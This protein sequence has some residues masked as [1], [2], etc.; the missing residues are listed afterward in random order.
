MLACL[1]SNVRPA[2]FEQLS[3]LPIHDAAIRSLA[4]NHHPQQRRQLLNIHK[5]KLEEFKKDSKE[6]WDTAYVNKRYSTSRF[7]ECIYA[8]PEILKNIE[9]TPSQFRENVPLV[10]DV[11]SNDKMSIN[12]LQFQLSNQ[13]AMLRRNMANE[14]EDLRMFQNREIEILI[15]AKDAR[16]LEFHKLVEETRKPGFRPPPDPHQVNKPIRKQSSLPTPA[17]V[18]SPA[19]RAPMAQRTASPVQI[20]S[21]AA[22]LPDLNTLQN[23][24]SLDTFLRILLQLTVVQR[25]WPAIAINWHQYYYM[26]KRTLLPAENFAKAVLEDAIRATNTTKFPVDQ[27]II[28]KTRTDAANFT[29]ILAGTKLL[30]GVVLAMAEAGDIEIASSATFSKEDTFGPT[31]LI[32]IMTIGTQMEGGQTGSARVGKAKDPRHRVNP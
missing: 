17:A 10:R 21:P 24:V 31:I 14:H 7:P 6:Q 8:T 11:M 4:G 19:I 23:D 29:D 12:E 30:I 15:K 9:S 18:S 26:F 28:D 1:V 32:E 25:N 3:P 13:A 5:R 20:Q 27:K 2:E 22:E 16:D